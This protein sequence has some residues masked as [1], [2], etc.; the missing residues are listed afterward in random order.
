[1][2]L[3]Y[4]VHI[5]V[6]SFSSHTHWLVEHKHWQCS[7]PFQGDSLLTQHVATTANSL[8]DHLLSP[9]VC[10]YL[11]SLVI[12]AAVYSSCCCCLLAAFHSKQVVKDV[13][14]QCS[15]WNAFRQ[16]IW[17]K[18]PRKSEWIKVWIVG[19]C[20]WVHCTAFLQSEDWWFDPRLC[21]LACRCVLG[22]D[23]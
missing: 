10:V 13:P 18:L 9:H 5:D 16:Y 6:C 19:E 15:F 7:A 1:M 2:H 23:S 11:T 8:E 4:A 21:Q 3:I 22:H 17:T 14:R 12:I 20:G